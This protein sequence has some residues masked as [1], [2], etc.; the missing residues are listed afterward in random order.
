MNTE[1]HSSESPMRRFLSHEL[2][3]YR[4]R[5]SVSA[6]LLLVGSLM[7]IVATG[8]DARTAAQARLAALPQES[9]APADNPSTPER[10]ALGACCSGIRSCPVRKMSRARRA[11]IRRSD[12]PTVSISRSAQTASDSARANL[13]PRHEGRPVKRNSQTVLNAAFNG[14]D[15][16]R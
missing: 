11:T 16:N 12:I 9:P 8:G 14:L 7:V 15:R 3:R 2:P 10:V 13:R 1:T 5:V 6:L 4:G